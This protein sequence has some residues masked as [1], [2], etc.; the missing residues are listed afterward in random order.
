MEFKLPKEAIK[1]VIA[2][3][4]IGVTTIWQY[5][6]YSDGS[7]SDP[8]VLKSY[9]YSPNSNKVTKQKKKAKVIKMDE[10]VEY[11]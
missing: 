7:T 1:K 10:E 11:R 8:V 9:S 4:V 6:I 2:T 3:K 5:N